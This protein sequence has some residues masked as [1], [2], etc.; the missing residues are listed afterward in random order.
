MANFT[1]QT[2]L[3]T[4]IGAA[5]SFLSILTNHNAEYKELV[6]KGVLQSQS[7][8]ADQKIEFIKGKKQRGA[9]KKGWSW[10]QHIHE[11]ADAAT[12]VEVYKA[13][14]EEA[15]K[16]KGL[17]KEQQNDFAVSRA[18]D[19]MSFANQGSDASVRMINQSVPFFNS[20]LNGMDVIL[21][22]ATGMNMSK[23]DAA[24]ARK[25]FRT[26]AIY[27]TLASMAYAYT[28]SSNSEEY[29]EAKASDWM[30]N[31]LI[32]GLGD[33]RMGKVASPF[34][35]GVT[36]KLIPEAMVR[37]MMGLDTGERTKELLFN[38]VL[39]GLT[40]PLPI[41]AFIKPILEATTGKA[42]FD[43]NPAE[44]FDI[45]SRGSKDLVRTERGRGKS[46]LSDAF[47]D[48]TG[49]SPAVSKQLLS[50]YGTEVFSVADMLANGLSKGFGEQVDKDWT[51]TVP[52]AKAFVTNPNSLADQNEVYDQ[53]EK[54]KQFANTMTHMLKVGDP[55]AALYSTSE[56]MPFLYGAK[57]ETKIVAA[58]T[59][60]TQAMAYTINDPSLTT[61]QKKKQYDE[62]LDVKRNILSIGADISKEA[63]KKAP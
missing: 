33:G 54:F 31:W 56:N 28:L 48:I 22:N 41:P 2:G 49:M 43:K 44:W 16:Q 59:K 61:A 45:E 7:N 20:F 30:S 58:M 32:P 26:R 21:R 35:I 8:L 13:A 6:N 46:Y 9:V 3:V 36:F 29:R 27:M 17:T 52:Y 23:A 53:A 14:L 25:L 19:F 57:A 34:E 15:K 4:P 38:S 51:E 39:N 60:L 62:L 40:P 1:A 47:S 24:R 37:Q 12:R 50:G 63:N 5:R 18:R 10:L 11:A 55:R 42:M